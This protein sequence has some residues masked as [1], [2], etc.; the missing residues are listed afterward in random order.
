MAGTIQEKRPY[1]VIR[2]D[3]T[4]RLFQKAQFAARDAVQEL[5]LGRPTKGFD[6]YGETEEIRAERIQEIN[7]E[8]SRLVPS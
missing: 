2:S 7:I 4:R 1:V 6:A 8:F 3:D 5:R